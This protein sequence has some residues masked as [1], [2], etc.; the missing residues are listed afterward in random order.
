MVTEL[1][2]GSVLDPPPPPPP[3][4][5]FP[6]RVSPAASKS[7]VASGSEVWK[8]YVSAPGGRRSV[9]VRA[10][11]QLVVEPSGHDFGSRVD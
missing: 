6:R 3:T 5:A 11:G 1:K 8:V 9:G 7:M 4:M 2:V 10:L